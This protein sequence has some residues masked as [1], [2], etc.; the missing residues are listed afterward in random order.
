MLLL[1]T[2]IV[3]FEWYT[4]FFNLAEEA[5][6][7]KNELFSTLK[8]TIC[9]KYSFQKLPQMSQ[10]NNVLDAPA[11]YTDGFLQPSWIGLFGTKWGYIQIENSDFQQVLLSKTNSF[12]TGKQCVICWSSNI[13]SYLWRDACVS[14]TLVKSP[15]WNKQSLPSL[16][17][18]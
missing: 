14:S 1:L 6:L 13:D 12:L 2:Q 9:R 17:N 18:T 3:F 15:I 11:S 10:G 5:Y 16:S 7:E 8:T 4:C